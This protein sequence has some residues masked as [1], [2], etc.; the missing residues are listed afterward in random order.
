MVVLALVS[1]VCGGGASDGDT[2][3]LSTTTE[4]LVASAD[5][6][7]TLLLAPGSLPEGVSPDDI[8]LEV[9]VIDSDDPAIP[10][11]VVQLLPDGLV[12]AE[13][14]S[15]TIALPQ[16][17]DGGLMA[18]LSS[19]DLIEFL[20]GRLEEVDGAFSYTT[21]VEHFSL[22]S[23]HA[24]F[25]VKVSVVADPSLVSIGDTQTVTAT[26]TTNIEPVTVW[27]SFGSEPGTAR[28]ITLSPQAPIRL[29]DPRIYWVPGYAGGG[30]V[31]GSSREV[32]RPHED[33]IRVGDVRVVYMLKHQ[34]RKSRN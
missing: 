32:R 16:A 22:V 27:M 5:G 11:V 31:L 8:Q 15:L 9:R 26:I 3:D 4:S 29:Y 7:A 25:F 19:G 28:L 23:V 20:G 24:F 33:S 1:T 18:I 21:S 34:H 30:G 17:P 10:I 12:L 6:L 2:A 14:A 13:P